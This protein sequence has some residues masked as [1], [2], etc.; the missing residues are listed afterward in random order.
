MSNFDR[1]V[2]RA[3]TA[4][5][6]WDLRTLLYGNDD[7][8]PLWVADM[9]F[10]SP[11][12]VIAAL[13]ERAQHGTYGY[14]ARPDS[15]YEA[16]QGWMQRRHG[17]EVPKEWIVP[18]PSLMTALGLLLQQ[19]TAPGDKVVVQ[20]PVYYSF[21]KIIKLS[22]REVAE[23]PLKIENG[24]Y[25]MDYEHL[26]QTFAAGAKLMLLCN[27]HNPVGRVWEPE[28]L[29]KLGELA[30]KHNVLVLS[31]EIHSDL[32]YRPYKHT[33][34]ATLSDAIGANTMTMVSPTKTFNLAGLKVAAMI[35]PNDRLRRQFH[36]QLTALAL[37]L[38]SYFGVTALE[39]AYTQCEPWLE[40]LLDYLQGNRDLVLE[41]FAQQ[42]PEIKAFQPEGT[43]LVWLDCR[44]L[45]LTDAELR[46][47]MIDDARVALSEG[48]TFGTGGEGFLRLNLACPR[49]TLEEGLRRLQA[50]YAT[51][52]ARI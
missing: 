51:L 39:V 41:T 3:N 25:V 35:I 30:L 13:T 17:W 21:H 9:D 33:V 49:S 37:E 27:P 15:F 44:A 31:D 16:V 24:R 22:E 14:T 19:L 28:E 48:P 4:S 32:I 1:V 34:F 29:R 6:K 20:S 8:L 43:Y 10:P 42:L 47:W 12:A 52:K 45:G 7:V 5:M 2:N 46:R 18:C 23:S 36:R 11:P 50:G 26:E 38:E 40:E